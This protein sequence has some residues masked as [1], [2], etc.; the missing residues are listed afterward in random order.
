MCSFSFQGRLFLKKRL[1]IVQRKP[2]VGGGSGDDSLTH[3]LPVYIS[4]LAKKLGQI[5][6]IKC[7]WRAVIS[8]TYLQ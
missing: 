4:I 8:F 7:V 2:R 6:K 5:K 1:E 3:Q